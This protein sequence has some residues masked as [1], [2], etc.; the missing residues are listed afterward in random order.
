[1]VLL[2][3]LVV[4]LLYQDWRH[5]EVFWRQQDGKQMVV[6]QMTPA[7]DNNYENLYNIKYHG[8]CAKY[9]INVIINVDI[10][11]INIRRMIHVKNNLRI[12]SLDVKRCDAILVAVDVMHLCNGLVGRSSALNDKLM[13]VLSLHIDCKH[14]FLPQQVAIHW[15]HQTSPVKY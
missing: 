4:I 8:D 3:Y 15:C 10:N 7:I 13:M 1:M 2:Q 14:Q 6:H 11:T 9:K 12:D 5:R